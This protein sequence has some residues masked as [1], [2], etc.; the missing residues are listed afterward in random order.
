MLRNGT[1]RIEI[2][3]RSSGPYHSIDFSPWPN[4]N[5]PFPNNPNL[6]RPSRHNASRRTLRP[7]GKHPEAHLKQ[8][9]VDPEVSLRPRLEPPR[10][11]PG[12]FLLLLTLPLTLQI[13]HFKTF[14]QLWAISAYRRRYP[15][16]GYMIRGFPS[17]PIIRTQKPYEQP[18]RI[19]NIT[20]VTTEW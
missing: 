11:S 8:S 10:G 16:I 12:E 2:V 7:A 14:N 1:Y 15:C 5:F 20:L 13:R 3:G 19:T 4:P 9:G 18:T 6:P 17:N